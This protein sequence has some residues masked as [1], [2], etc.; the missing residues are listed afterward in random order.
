M[1]TLQNTQCLKG[2]DKKAR[3]PPRRVGSYVKANHTYRYAA[4]LFQIMK[5]DILFLNLYSLLEW[6]FEF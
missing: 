3:K 4:V 5:F 2:E 1:N 6:P